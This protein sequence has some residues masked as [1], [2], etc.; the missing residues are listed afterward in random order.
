VFYLYF[1]IHTTPEREDA[2]LRS[3]ALKKWL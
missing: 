2:L 3:V 1:E